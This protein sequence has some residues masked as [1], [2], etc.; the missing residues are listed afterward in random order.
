MVLLATMLT[1]MAIP[2][3]A[4]GKEKV[5]VPSEVHLHYTGKELTAFED[6]DKYTVVDGK[7][8]GTGN[9]YAILELKDTNKYE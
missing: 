2:T 8:T 9:Y 3:F 4:A 6:T 5:K 1:V 7:K